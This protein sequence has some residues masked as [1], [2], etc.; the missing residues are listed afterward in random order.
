M[1]SLRRLAASLAQQTGR[2][3]ETIE[4]RLTP[5]ALAADV[6][7]DVSRVQEVLRR[8][9]RVRVTSEAADGTVVVPSLARLLE[10]LEFLEMPR[11]SSGAAS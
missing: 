9:R 7:V 6:G 2:A 11:A 10:F 4:T 8:L 1:L 3:E 5:A